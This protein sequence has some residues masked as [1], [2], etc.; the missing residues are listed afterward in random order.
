MANA[1]FSYQISMFYILIFEYNISVWLC[2]STCYFSVIG[3]SYNLSYTFPYTH[4]PSSICS[5]IS[6]HFAV[7]Y[8]QATVFYHTKN[9]D[10]LRKVNPDLY[11]HK[12]YFSFLHP[13]D[14]ILLP[15]LLSLRFQPHGADF[16]P[17]LLS[18]PLPAPL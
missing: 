16:S 12:F 6:Y 7:L 3:I 10:P 13:Y 11:T 17:E 9:Q 1:F 14:I 15:V 18:L 8:S 5:F 2:Q 4:K